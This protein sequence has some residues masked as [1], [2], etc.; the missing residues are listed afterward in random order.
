MLIRSLRRLHNN[1]RGFFPPLSPSPDFCL[2][3][4]GVHELFEY[5]SFYSHSV[6]KP[7]QLPEENNRFAVA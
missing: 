5:L 6:K 3:T 1:Y 7:V 4:A 2:N